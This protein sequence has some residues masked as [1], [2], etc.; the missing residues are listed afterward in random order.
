M[1]LVAEHAPA[2]S[3][4]HAY[5]RIG[6]KVKSPAFGYYRRLE[7]YRRNIKAKL[8]DERNDVAE[9]TVFY[10]EGSNKKH[11]PQARENCERNKG[12]QEEQVPRRHKS[13]KN[14]QDK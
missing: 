7:T 10:V 2:K 1:A 12:G 13:I 11:R 14:H 5:H 9:V 3:V 6:T 4:N 8:H